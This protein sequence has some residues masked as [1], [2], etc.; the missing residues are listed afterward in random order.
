MICYKDKTFCASEV[1][2]HTCGRELKEEDKKKAEEIGLPIAYGEFCE[3]DLTEK[4]SIKVENKD[5][6]IINKLKGLE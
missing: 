5:I 2:K 1:E 3:E 6:T 4:I